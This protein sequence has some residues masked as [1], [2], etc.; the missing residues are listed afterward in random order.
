MF[1]LFFGLRQFLLNNLLNHILLSHS[2][3]LF[4]RFNYALKFLTPMQRVKQLKFDFNGT[5]KDMDKLKAL[6]DKYEINYTTKV[7]E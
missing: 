6:M 1:I 3:L 4:I 5:Q 2:L 7:S